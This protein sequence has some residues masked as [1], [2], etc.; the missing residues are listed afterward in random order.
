M[1]PRP[2][3]F[4]FGLSLGVI[5]FF[6]LARFVVL[7][8]FFA[9]AMSVVFFLGRK[10]KNFFRR[11][12]WE[13]EYDYEYEGNKAFAQQAPVWKGDMLLHYPTRRK[14]FMTDHRTIKVL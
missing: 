3:K 8:F 11:M 12:Q 2:F 1:R 5:L 6:F 4:F 7:A 9:A 14:A 13:D 10:I